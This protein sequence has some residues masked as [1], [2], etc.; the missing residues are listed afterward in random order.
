MRVQPTD[1]FDPERRQLVHRRSFLAICLVASLATDLSHAA[2]R[3]HLLG[4]ASPGGTFHPVGVALATVINATLQKAHGIELTAV[5]TAGSAENVHLMQR[6]ELQFGVLQGLFGHEART[7]SG[8]FAG[9]HRANMLRS[10]TTLWPNLEQFVIRSEDLE[11]GT[12]DDLLR[13]KGE[14]VVLGDK[15][16]GTFASSRF[17]LENLGADVERDFILVHLA[18]GPAADALQKGEVA[19]VALAAGLPTKSLARLKS[20]MG[21]GA[22]ILAFTADQARTA[23]G[24]LRLWRPYRISADTYPGQGQDVTTI[25]QPN[26]LAVRSDVGEEDVYLMTKAVFENLP[27]LGSMHEATMDIS[28]EGAVS[29]LPLPL[30]PGAARY[31]REMGLEIPADLIVD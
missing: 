30:H 10:V 8:E 31:F 24:G 21:D 22:V 20:E 26:F 19:A 5:A 7:G 1:H 17:L 6:G 11:S 3:A 4:T 27:L 25:A 15:G 2:E 28:L 14:R 13:M 16:S 18:Y 29:G 12:I 9:L 23:D